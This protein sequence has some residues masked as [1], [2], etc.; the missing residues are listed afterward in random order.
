M[1]REGKVKGHSS[2]EEEKEGRNYATNP[3]TVKTRKKN[4]E[5]EGHDY[6]NNKI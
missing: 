2:A 6:D 3:G 5:G 1:G 4:E